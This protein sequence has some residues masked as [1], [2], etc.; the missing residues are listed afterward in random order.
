ML[1]MTRTD[2]RKLHVLDLDR[3]CCKVA[4]HKP[5]RGCASTSLRA[6]LS[7]Y[8]PLGKRSS[9]VFGISNNELPMIMNKIADQCVSARKAA[10]N[11]K[12][13]ASFARP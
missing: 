9:S 6:P 4:P 5:D 7:I 11:D 10:L 13:R 2:T 8:S 1:S 3:C 12:W